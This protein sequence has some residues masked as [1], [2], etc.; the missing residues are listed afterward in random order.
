MWNSFKFISQI[1][2]KISYENVGNVQTFA[3]LFFFSKD[4]KKCEACISLRSSDTGS[5]ECIPANLKKRSKGDAAIPLV[6]N[7]SKLSNKR[8]A[9]DEVPEVKVK[10]LKVV[11][12]KEEIDSG[13][14]EMK[15]S[16]SESEEVRDLLFD[17]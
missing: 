14:D 11:S 1:D 7:T 16:D 3:T 13:V 9:D 4:S 2:F 12:E 8:A 5:P 15:D 17:W 6:Q 10:R